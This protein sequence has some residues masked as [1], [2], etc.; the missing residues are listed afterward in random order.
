METKLEQEKKKDLLACHL[1]GLLLF[2]YYEYTD[3]S[4][5]YHAI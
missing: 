1:N 2:V 4:I 3:I 5:Y